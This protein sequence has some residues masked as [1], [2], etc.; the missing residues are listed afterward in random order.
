MDGSDV[1]EDVRFTKGKVVGVF[2]YA[3]GEHK[4]DVGLFMMKNFSGTEKLHNLDQR[5]HQNE[6]CV[7]VSERDT[8][9]WK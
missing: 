6:L 7:C 4:A 9:P 5:R 1:C 3:G 8:E 2:S